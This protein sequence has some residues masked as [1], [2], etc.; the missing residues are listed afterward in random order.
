MESESNLDLIVAASSGDVEAARRAIES[1]ANVNCTSD[2]EP[3]EGV[4][5]LMLAVKYCHESMARYLLS[6][7]LNLERRARAIVPGDASRETALHWAVRDA[8]ERICRLLISAGADVNAESTR[9]SVL[10]YAIESGN[11]RIIKMLIEAGSN[12]KKPTGNE[13]YLPILVAAKTGNTKA[14]NLLHAKGAKLV[15]HPL[16]KETPLMK[17]CRLE[18]PAA[19][20][21][22][23][24][25][26]DKP[27]ARDK[28]GWT[29]LMHAAWGGNEEC[30]KALLKKG[31]D[32]LAKDPEGKT[33]WDFAFALRFHAAAYWLEKA[34]GK[35]TVI[36]LPQY[37]PYP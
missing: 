4:T 20:K 13:K 15:P 29:P 21:L 34:G 37:R 7:G 19:V 36:G 10:Q 33:A 26:G 35:T 24:A 27:E 22:L 31:V 17:A 11:N 3:Y 32:V 25:L 5:P 1:G 30:I 2:L 9:G 23:L 8:L 18:H 12:F 28:N 16:S 6:T 14:I